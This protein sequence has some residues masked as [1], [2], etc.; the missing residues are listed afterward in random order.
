MTDRPFDRW[1]G[2][3]RY[4]HMSTFRLATIDKADPKQVMIEETLSEMIHDMLDT[5][6]P[7]EFADLARTASQMM[8]TAY[9]EQGLP[10]PSD[11]ADLVHLTDEQIVARNAEKAK[12]HRELDDLICPDTWNYRT[13]T[14]HP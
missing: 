9:A 8:L 5:M 14:S 6:P 1:D 13:E 7:E 3:R 2:L 4:L 12:W 10:V 11:I